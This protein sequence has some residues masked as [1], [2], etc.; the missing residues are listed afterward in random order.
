MIT[1]INIGGLA[2]R[3]DNTVTIWSDLAATI[4]TSSK[5]LQK[6]NVSG[7][8]EF[9]P[10]VKIIGLPISLLNFSAAPNGNVVDIKWATATEINNS[11]FTIERTTDG[12]NYETVAT[13]KG[14]G[15]TNYEIN[16]AATDANPVSGISYYRLRQTDFDGKS[17]TFEAVVV[18]YT[19]S[20][21]NSLNV[22]SVYPNPFGNSF[23]VNLECN[24]AKTLNIE[25]LSINGLTIDKETVSCTEGSNTYKY[26]KGYML[27]T[28]TY[29][30]SVTDSSN[31]QTTVKKIV[32]L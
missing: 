23:S 11:F 4:N 12:I 1:S 24:N 8:N 22:K 28:G 13:V 2:M 7:R 21:S 17:K 19:E 16:Y 15:N 9:I 10:A 31:G 26:A 32:K 5:M 27:T 29:F 3:S 20:T 6:A 25:I 14:S 30:V 18:T